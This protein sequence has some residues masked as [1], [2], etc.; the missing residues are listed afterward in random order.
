MAAIDMMRTFKEQAAAARA[1]GLKR[2]IAD[3]QCRHDH[4]ERRADDKGMCIACY[5]LRHS[6]RFVLLQSR[7]RVITPAKPP[8]GAPGSEKRQVP[9]RNP[10][11]KI[12]GC[13]EMQGAILRLVPPRPWLPRSGQFYKRC[14]E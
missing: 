6:N 10:R 4:V 2:F 9:A 12:A 8:R 7:T 11:R 3:R 1:A 14:R 13:S 5:Y